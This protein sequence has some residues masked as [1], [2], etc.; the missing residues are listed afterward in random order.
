M[1][2]IAAAIGAG[3]VLAALF[4]G[5]A[6]A[7]GTRG[8]SG[9]EPHRQIGGLAEPIARFTVA[10][11][12]G[13]DRQRAAGDDGRHDRLRAPLAG[14]IGGVVAARDATPPTGPRRLAAASSPAKV[15]LPRVGTS[16]PAGAAERERLRPASVARAAQRVEMSRLATDRARQP[17]SAAPDPPAVHGPA[18]APVVGLITAPLPSVVDIVSTVPVRPVVM[19]LLG[20]ADAV[21]TP[22]LGAVIVP[23]ATP[24]LPVPP[25][26]GPAAVPVTAPAAIPTVPTSP[27]NP[28][29]APVHAAALPTP[30]APPPTSA[31]GPARA[32]STTRHLTVKAGPVTAEGDLSGQPVA[33]VD[34]DAAGVG[35]GSTP[36]PGLAWPLDRPSRL[37]AG[38]P[39]DLVPLL[40]ESRTPSGIAR[41]G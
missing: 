7:D 9:D 41:P 32:M 20:V 17:A 13:Q 22:D 23:A 34:Q 28:A 30:A 5:P 19:A 12:P 24:P 29:L 16:V 8:G 18:D 14:A 35:D 36:G 4:Q 15:P 6:A 2:L 11:R 10:E 1:V 31:V 27:A 26:R 21:L 25:V 39:C 38:Q 33:P 37:G 40:V 3:F